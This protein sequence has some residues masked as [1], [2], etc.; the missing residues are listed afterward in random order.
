MLQPTRSCSVST[1]F[2]EVYAHYSNQVVSLSSPESVNPGVI[3]DLEHS[4]AHL[5]DIKNELRFAAREV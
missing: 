4:E 3:T 2:D 5:L 1:F